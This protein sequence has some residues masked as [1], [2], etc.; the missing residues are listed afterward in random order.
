MSNSE[1][2]LVLRL[3]RGTGQAV[4]EQVAD[5]IRS[6]VREEHLLPRQ[7]LPGLR[8]LARGAGAHPSLVAR[9]LERLDRE[10]WIE[11]VDSG[12]VVAESQPLVGGRESLDSQIESAR[13]AQQR[14]LPEDL[15]MGEI[16]IV[17]Y[18]DA[19]HE[20]SGDFYDWFSDAS[21]RRWTVAVGDVA[22]KGLAAGLVM[23]SV[24]TALRMSAGRDEPGRVIT[25]LNVE[26][27]ER[28]RARDFVALSVLDLDLDQLTLRASSAGAP[29][30]LMKTAA[31]MESLVVPGPRLPLGLRPAV[32]YETRTLQLSPGDQLLIVSDGL[33]E[34]PTGDGDLLGYARF[35]ERARGL[36]ETSEF[37]SRALRS[38]VQDLD[39]DFGGQPSDDRTAVWVRVGKP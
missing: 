7:P 1:I 30:V 18:S 5:Q 37:S 13:E 36:T 29:D 16:G 38:F 39:T 26:V 21:G 35:E 14:L 3:K 20:V 8:S 19:L 33:P 15:E 6:W 12:Y 9:G 11:S 23:A 32:A 28:T 24:Q 27:A 22:G 31:G 4:P 10:G 34:T 2:P 17:S 25:D